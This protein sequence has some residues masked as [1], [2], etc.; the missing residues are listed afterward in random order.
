MLVLLA[1]ACGDDRPQD[2]AGSTN[3]PASRIIT[4]SP[5]LTELVY[6]TGAG[7]RLVGA[8]EYSDFPSA[9]L[10]LPRIG[11]AFRL[12][13][14]AII[15]LDPDLV[16]A[17]SSGTPRE[18]VNRLEQL[19]FRVVSLETGSLGGVADNV[20]EIGRLTGTQWQAEAVAA[21]FERSL[22]GIRTAAA[23]LAPVTVFYQVTAQPLLTISRR[24]VIGEAIELCGGRNVFG[25]LPD[26]TPSVSPEA[27]I[28]AAPAAIIA[29]RFTPDD[30]SAA[31]GL[32]FWRQWT[33]IPAVH[34]DSLYL[35]DAN[36]IV[37]SSVRVLGGVRELCASIAA[38]RKKM[39]SDTNIQDRNQ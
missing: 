36:L 22:E 39:V 35:V 12:D 26:L 18:V 30:A 24:H 17:W 14:E 23:G 33:S 6:S 2:R 25:D 3:D 15:G 5:H 32:A 4:L 19:G 11:D 21:D 7:D 16:L 28:D 8:V 34:T 38:A 31:A 10:A 20:R 1:P 9:A 27:V 37:R 29:G 13:Y